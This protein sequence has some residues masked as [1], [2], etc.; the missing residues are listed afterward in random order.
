MAFTA[1]LPL[2]LTGNGPARM[3]SGTDVIPV[4]LGG[5]GTSLA[6]TGGANQVVQQSTVG[7]NLSVAQLGFTALSGLASPSQIGTGTPVSG[8][9][10]DGGTGAWTSLPAPTDVQTSAAIYA[11]TLGGSVNT[12]TASVPTAPTLASGILVTFVVGAS[13]GNTGA[14][15]LNI[16]STGAKAIQ[17][18]GAALASGKLVAGRA[19]AAIYDGTQWEL[20]TNTALVA[21]DIPNLPASILTS[22]QL[23]L[24][25][26]GTNADL[27]AT[28]GAHQ[29]LQQS[30]VGGAITVAQPAFT[31]VSGT[32]TTSQIGTG[33]PAA[34]T[35]VDGATG[36]WTALPAGNTATLTNGESSAG[37]VPGAP[38]YSSAA[39]SVKR[40]QANALAT[41]QIVGLSL[42]T[43]AA[44]GSATVQVSG[45]VTL[46][47]GQWD[48]VAGTTGGLT[49]GTYYYIDPA[50]PGKLV[51]AGP[52]A[53]GQFWVQ[54]GVAISTTTLT[55]RPQGPI[56]A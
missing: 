35:Y 34:G 36:A 13:L 56:G 48:A 7:G 49:F 18:N 40:A 32:A 27:S 3:A 15:T 17:Y 28:G 46:T 45:D 30:T 10:V 20:L 55:L 29:F 9:Y 21:A 31:D 43:T 44:A 22:G 41:S 23:A 33:T 6:A 8:Q 52:T 51:S 38:V 50:N 12:Y 16:N 2:K 53:T 42:T 11:G 26:G 5:A 37:L 14:S 1:Q 39:G 47:T 25:R 54:V 19:Y 4:A 24:A